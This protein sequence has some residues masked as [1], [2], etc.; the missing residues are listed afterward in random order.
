MNM[1]AWYFIKNELE[2]LP[3][4]GIYRKASGSPAV[5]LNELHHIQ[6]NEIINKVFKPCNCELKHKYCGLQ[7]KTGKERIPIEKQHRYFTT[8]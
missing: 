3:I 2:H 8:E 7:C 4:E 6:Q 5:G 1:G